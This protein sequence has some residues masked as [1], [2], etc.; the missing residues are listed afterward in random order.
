VWAGA[1]LFAAVPA[2]A[3]DDQPA[4]GTQPRAVEVI[5]YPILVQAPIFGATI[6]LP[7]L[8][9]GGGGGE[10]GEQSASTGVSLNSAY[11]AGVAI[12]APRWFAEARGVW[13]DLA[14]SRETPRVSL[15]TEARLFNARGG[16]RLAGGLAATGGVRR[17]SIDLDATLALPALGREI[18]GTTTAVYWDPLVG[19]DW[20]QPMGRWILDANFQGGGFGVGADVDLS[21]EVHANWRLI[22]HTEIRLGY[23]FV[24]YKLTV[25]NVSIGA[26]QRTLVSS[27][28]LHGPIVGIGFFF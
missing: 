19:V 4:S 14:A 16:V 2:L 20:R 12:H 13:A 1:A 18:S 3:A 11:M 28:T 6:D 21:G 26:F 10:G 7:S 5:V 25:A 15:D 8:P 9:G 27:Q 24:Y 22:P 17:V 23:T